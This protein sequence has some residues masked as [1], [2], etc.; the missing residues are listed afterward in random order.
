MQHPVSIRPY[1]WEG[2][3]ALMRDRR[4]ARHDEGLC[5]DVRTHWMAPDERIIIRSSE[6]IGY[7]EAYLYDDHFPPFD[8]DGRGR[9]YRHNRF[10]WK[11]DGPPRELSASCPVTGKGEFTIGLTAEDDAVGVHLE[12]RSDIPQMGPIDWSFCVIAYECPTIGNPELDRTFIFDGRELHC[13]REL[14]G[15]A[16]CEL[17]P[18]AGSG[19]FVPEAF[20]TMPFGPE[21]SETSLIIVESRAGD[22]TVALGFDQSYLCY[23]NPE[24]MCFHADPFLGTIEHRGDVSWADGRLYLIDGDARKAFDRYQEDFLRPMI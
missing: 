22:R 19:G 17:Y 5:A 6:I 11:I 15:G 21:S 14:S 23:S 16:E 4:R 2:P 12:I 7:P 18:I 20:R 3:Y 13:L 1:L 8:A 24:N 10:T 9:D